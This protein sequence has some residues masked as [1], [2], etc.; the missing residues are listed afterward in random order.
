MDNFLK[1]SKQ[2]SIESL[3]F[4]YFLHELLFPLV[5]E[6]ENN[7]NPL[8]TDF[9]KVLTSFYL[10]ESK[11]VNAYRQALTDSV[12]WKSRKFYR[13]TMQ[14]FVTAELSSLE[15]AEE[16]SDRLLAQKAEANN[17]LKDF[18]KQA[19]IELNPK[20]FQFSRIILEFELPLLAYQDEMEDLEAADQLTK[21]NLSFT[22]DFL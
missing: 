5:D 3:E 11:K 22:E 10:G 13:E 20:S 2:Q 12:F 7:K 4:F 17:L 6:Y 16:F 14:K 18:Q 1:E 15:F 19:N 9:L 21:D 8:I